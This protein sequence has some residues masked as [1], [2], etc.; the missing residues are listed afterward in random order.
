MPVSGGALQNSISSSF[1]FYGSAGMLCATLH[2]WWHQAL[3]GCG[4]AVA[5][6]RRSKQ[7]ITAACWLS[8]AL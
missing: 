3:L 7:A 2:M 8:D 5:R 6:V 4:F 1:L